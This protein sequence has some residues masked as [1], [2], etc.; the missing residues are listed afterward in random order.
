MVHKDIFKTIK[1]YTLLITYIS[2]FNCA[3]NNVIQYWENP[4]IVGENKEAGH[5]T[6]MPFNSLTKALGGSFKK[7]SHYF[8]LNGLWKFKWVPKPSDRPTSFFHSNFNDNTW[9]DIVVPSSWQL[10]GYGQPIYTN[11]KHPFPDPTPPFPPENNNPV[12]SYRR[13][14][15]LPDNWSAGQVFIHFDGVKSAFFLWINGKKVGYS[16][17]SMTP[18][19]FNITP[20]LKK[21]ENQIAAQVFRWSDASYIEDQDFWRLS[22]IYRNVYLMHVPD[23]H[24]RHYKAIGSLENNYTD[25]LLSIAVNLNNYSSS[26]QFGILSAAIYD[27]LRNEIIKSRPIKVLLQPNFESEIELDL[28]V[29]NVK[30]WSAELP[31]LYTLVLSFENEKTQKTEYI[32][33]KTGFRSIELFNGQLLINGEPIILKGVNRHEHDPKT[34]RTISQESMTKDIKLMKQFNINAVRTSHYPNDPLW[35][36]LCD[37]YGLYLYDEANIES[38]AFWSKFTLDPKWK[39]AFLERVQRMVLRDVNH[40]SIIVWS[41]GNEAGYGPNHDIMAEWVRN[42]DPARL[43]HYEGKEPGYGPE[44]NHFDIIANMYASVDHMIKLHN[45]NPDRPVILCEYSHAMGNSNGNIF[46]YWDAIYSYPRLQGAFVWDWVDQGLLRK[47]EKGTYYVYGGDFGEELHDGNF[48]I[49][50]VI[51]PDRRPK[52]GLYE[53]KHLSQN[54]KVSKKKNIN[55][56]GVLNRNFFQDLNHL[57]GQCDILENGLKIGTFELNIKNIAAGTEKNI[58]IPI[59][60]TIEMR[61]EKEYCANFIFSLKEDLPWAKKGHIAASDQIILQTS[62][63]LFSTNIPFSKIEPIKSFKEGATLNIIASGKTYQLNTETG[64][65]SG[66]LIE[67]KPYLS[68]PIQFNVWRASTDNDEGGGKQSFASQWVNAG[69]D[70]LVRKM[71]NIEIK[72]IYPEKT[73]INVSE[74]HIGKKEDIDVVVGYTFFNNG[75]LLINLRTVVPSGLPVLPKLGITFKTPEEFSELTWYGRGPHES[76]SD[77]KQSAFL[78]KYRGSVLEQYFPYIRP[79]ENGNKTNVRWASLENQSGNGFVVFG[80]PEFNFSAHHYSYKNLTD[81]T[82]TYTINKSGPITVNID[83]RMMG[84]GGD[85]SWN[86]RTHKEYLVYPG[87][88]NYSF[89]IRFSK[90]TKKSLSLPLPKTK[91]KPN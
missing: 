72:N 45:E 82:H 14:F 18:A 43:I 44:P 32:S 81:A 60:S 31:N 84:L 39:T 91:A 17:G 88:F 90:D 1:L 68:S 85:D 5:A 15:L 6:L 37:K 69:Y 77:R 35:Y 10:E 74:K 16:Q 59:S 38:H 29:K 9:D 71:Q 57:L 76:Y 49:N 75:D 56:Y 55:N 58:Y 87:A 67:N 46:K 28:I 66:V 4:K 79:Q 80:L 3:D 2:V 34:G 65:L 36:K 52:P 48:C 54:V 53:I 51:S 20:Y 7:S 41:L 21:G 89:I 30:P 70:N 25:G 83:H 8:D 33:C 12:G 61:P 19:E 11:V 78:G 42:Y 73:H 86:P 64:Q 22:G 62:K 50:G 13:K 47:D 24:I 27:T 40:P 63:N 23:L 26:E